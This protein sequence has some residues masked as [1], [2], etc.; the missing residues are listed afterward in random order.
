M[1]IGWSSLAMMVVAVGACAVP[2]PQASR[3]DWLTMRIA[4]IE[5]EPVANPPALIARYDYK[6]QPVYY[7]PPRCCDIPSDVYDTTGAVIC[8]ADGG[9]TGKGDGRCAD[10]LAERRNEKVIWRDPRPAPS[11]NSQDMDED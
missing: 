2:G 9:Y 4:E 10:F 5:R 3:P 11:S 1:T 6:G 7:L 8:H